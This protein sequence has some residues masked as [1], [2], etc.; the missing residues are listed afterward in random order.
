MSDG[1]GFRKLREW[2]DSGLLVRPSA[3][4]PHFMDLVHALAALAGAEG[5][6]HGP[7]AE[8]IRRMIGPADHYL[9][10][11]VD[12]MGLH[13]L[14]HLPEKGFLRSSVAA[15]L[16]ALF[17]STTATALT[18]L[19]TGVWPC[20]HGVPGWWTRLEEA[21][22]SAVTLPFL[23]RATESPLEDRGVFAQEVFPV[24]SF[25]PELEN[26]A[27]SILPAEILDTTYSTYMCG[28]TPRIGYAGIADALEKAR[29]AVLDAPEHRFTYL[30]LPQLDTLC[31]GKGTKDQEVQ[32]LL[33]ALDQRLLRL[34]ESVAGRARIVVSADHGQ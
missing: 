21:G 20:V 34:C 32:D 9:F 3:Q 17:P 18:S 12:G 15:R 5:M 6:K 14:E 2:F 10:V 16:H 23:D 26:G 29:D 1:T 19:G 8:E 27:L 30:Y 33:R 24:P 22:I 13:Q 7:G 11:L 25:W 4:V 28:N 31:H